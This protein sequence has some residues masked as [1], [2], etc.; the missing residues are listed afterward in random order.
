MGK[1]KPKKSKPTQAKKARGRPTVYDPVKAAKVLELHAAGKTIAEIGRMP[2][3]PAET[4]IRG[5]AV[6]DT[7]GFAVPYARA[8]EE[9]Y[10]WWASRLYGISSG[11]KTAGSTGDVNR[12]RLLADSIKWASSRLLRHRGYGDQV[13]VDM[14]ASV[15]LG[16]MDDQQLNATIA[17]RLAKLGLPA[18]IMGAFTVLALPKPEGTGGDDNA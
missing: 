6:Q 9:Y 1:A 17:A 5:W 8:R 2:N 16:T 18:E 4:T 7:A 11:D 15:G 3:M 10:E 12:D 14:N 13:Q